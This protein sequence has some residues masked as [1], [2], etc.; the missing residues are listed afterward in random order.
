MYTKSEIESND[1]I[2]KVDHDESYNLDLFTYTTCTNDE[3]SEM[4][5]NSRGVVYANDE[6]ILQSFP[7]TPEFNEY[8]IDK[9]ETH[10]TDAMVKNT[11]FYDSYEGTLIRVFYFK[12]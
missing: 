12:D 3:M 10:L 11:L 9:I 1:N 8:E 4:V 7:Y 2:K 6:L 5:K